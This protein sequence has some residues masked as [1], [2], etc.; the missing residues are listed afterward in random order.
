MAE[1]VAGSAMKF[2]AIDLVADFVFFPVWWYTAGL[3]RTL[4][5]AGRWLNYGRQI[6][7]VGLWVKN[8]FTPMFAQYDLGGRVISF[9]VRVAMILARSVGLAIIAALAVLFILAWLA[10][11]IFLA[12]LV[13]GQLVGL[14]AGN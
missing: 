5:A 9:F 10:F 8:I 1:S 7:A 3:V 13:F 11:P 12:W 14:F 2:V 6:M 4:R